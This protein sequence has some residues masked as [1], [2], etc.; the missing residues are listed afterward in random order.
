[1]HGSSEPFWIFIED[2]NGEEILHHEF[3]LLSDKMGVEQR[4]YTCSITV[5]LFE[6]LHPL[7]YIKVISDRWLNSE[8]IMPISFKN[9]ILPER[10]SGISIFYFLI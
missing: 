5:P 7:Y 1:M 3:F 9:L 6:N 8:T 4:D 10:F 2:C